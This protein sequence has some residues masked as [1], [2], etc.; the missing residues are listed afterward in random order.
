MGLIGI[1]MTILYFKIKPETSLNR[2]LRRKYPFSRARLP[3]FWLK[4]EFL[5]DVK[6][7]YNLIFKDFKEICKVKIIN[8]ENAIPE[9][10]KETIDF[11]DI[12]KNN[13]NPYKD[14]NIQALAQ[15]LLQIKKKLKLKLR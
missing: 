1:P 13:K 11:L 9:V 5:S 7:G 15:K 3:D 10:Y 12:T 14:L 2:T 6:M 4:K 8:S